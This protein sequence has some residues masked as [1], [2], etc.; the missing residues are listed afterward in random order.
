MFWDCK[1]ECDSDIDR[2]TPIKLEYDGCFVI[3]DLTFWEG[4]NSDNGQQK[5]E[6]GK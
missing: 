4:V 1:V 5:T 2:D 6:N 3:L